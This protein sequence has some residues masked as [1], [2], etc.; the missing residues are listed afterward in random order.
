MGGEGRGGGGGGGGG[1]GRDGVTS[2][3]VSVQQNKNTQCR[4]SRSYASKCLCM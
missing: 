3:L 4:P 1:L 2:V